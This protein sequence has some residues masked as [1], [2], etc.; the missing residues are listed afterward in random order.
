MKKLSLALMLCLSCLF[1][2][3]LYAAGY[4][5]GSG[6]DE[7]PYQISSVADW[8]ELM[9]TPD[10]WA[11]YFVLTANID[12]QGITLTPVGN[13]E[14]EFT[15]S[16]NG[17]GHT[18]SNVLIEQTSNGAGLFGRVGIDG[19]IWNLGVV[20][21]DIQGGYYVGG[22]VGINDGM[23]TSCYTTGIVSGGDSVGGLVGENI[24]HLI[25]CYSSS[26]ISG[27]L[28][29][30]G[31][32]GSNY[33]LIANSCATGSVNGGDSSNKLGGLCGVNSSIC[34]IINCYATG[35]VT[36]GSG[37]SGLGGL[38]GWNYYG[39]ISNCYSVG[40]VAGGTSAYNLGGFCGYQ[41]GSDPEMTNSF[42]DTDASTMTVGYNL[43]PVLP[44]TVTN[45][46]GK[47]TA[48]MQTLSTFTDAGWDFSATD[49]DAA[50]WQMPTGDYPRLVWE[51][52][53]EFSPDGGTYLSK[54]NVTITCS[55]STAVI[56]YT[57]DGRTPTES[58]PVIASGSSV[59]I[60]RSMTLKARAWETGDPLPG[61][62]KSAAFQINLICPTAD[63]NGDCKVDL[64][65]FAILSQWWLDVCNPFNQ[66]CG[67]TDLDLSGV[68]DLGELEDVVEETLEGEDIADHVIGIA[69]D[70]EWDYQEI[71]NPNVSYNFQVSVD[72]DETV[73]LVSFT[74]P[75][76]STILIPAMDK[77]WDIPEPNG[78]LT[79]G[80]ESWIPGEYNWEY[81]YKFSTPG[82]LSAYGDGLY[83]ITVYY[84][85]GGT[86]QTT[87]WFGIPGTTDPLPQPT[88]EP[89]FTSI[90]N[91]GMFSSPVTFAWDACTDPAV[92]YIFF[93]T[94]SWETGLPDH[95]YTLSPQAVGLSTP[96]AMTPGEYSVFLTFISG[97]DR[98]DIVNDDGIP[99]S[100]Y[101]SCG[102]WGCV[103]TV[104]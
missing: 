7:S 12:M 54:Q 95:F 10:D 74:T 89:V 93:M 80:V 68:V 102:N 104:E 85:D 87:V 41:S 70:M 94:I 90:H 59:L 40:T 16:F 57:I 60:S 101:K 67:G 8:Q 100:A 65:D 15:G 21:A 62:V 22:L 58:D 82:P 51:K 18:I 3:T 27:T 73:A 83:T 37:S 96:I 17:D 81:R 71:D 56:H 91:G 55:S 50:D 47:T 25:Q 33:G 77:V 66:W 42:W 88:Q 28:V 29:V 49:G 31:L 44:G 11:S 13:S 6:I 20:D 84:T 30:G 9:A 72:T 24:G 78:L 5:G 39:V 4:S 36:G 69:I 98:W 43:D 46:P 92:G 76:G 86:Q 34:T 103:I 14:T 53:I 2:S 45:V 64:E 48:L 61:P 23:I 79:L 99:Y 97:D 35:A 1:G 19:Q 26:S 32:C 75:T 38:C 52:R 63:L